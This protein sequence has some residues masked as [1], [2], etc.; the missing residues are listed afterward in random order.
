MILM[1][2][3]EGPGGGYLHAP[4]SK[5][6][7]KLLTLAALGL[8]AGANAQ[9]QM[10]PQLGI[11]ACKLAG[12]DVPGLE[13]KAAIGWQLGID[14]RIGDRLYLQPGVHFVRTATAVKYT[15]SDTA[16]LE[17]NLIRS[18]VKA[19]LLVGYNL[20]HDETFK[21]RLNAGPTY[22]VLLSVDSKDD[23]IAFNK[24]DYNGGSFNMDAGLGL[25]IW[26]LTV[27]SGVSYGLSNSYED[28]GELSNDSKYF[29]W[30]LSAGIVIGSS[31]K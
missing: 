28:Q 27:E 17:D 3:A 26:I 21:L 2:P 16:V 23:E 20:I 31:G 4:T 6:M 9:F 29:T 18:S 8:T 7:K 24:D 15:A 5:L 13:Y 10:N 1:E 12:D 11:N 19:K 22:D 14:F 30:Y 25:D